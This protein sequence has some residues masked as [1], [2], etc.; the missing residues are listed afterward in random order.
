MAVYLDHNAST[1]L[2]EDVLQAMLP[3]MQTMTGNP[4]S[5]HRFGRLQKDTIERARQ[6]VADLVSAN[7]DQVVFTSG[8]T[9]AN[10]LLVKGMAASADINRMAIS[11]VEH[12]AM[13]EPAAQIA[14]KCAVDYIAVDRD[15]RVTPN[16]LEQAILPDTRLVSVMSANNETGVIQDIASLAEIAGRKN[17]WFHTDAS[18]AAGKIDVSFKDWGVH[19]MTLSSHKIY[20]PPG[21]GALVIDKGLPLHAL[22]HGGVQEQR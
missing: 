2:H 6:Q 14:D 10:N 3:V 9:E 16:T 21:A 18:Q 8:G 17:I 20:G 4:S 13:L 22:L 1:P 5:L 12:M 15:G 11:S 7:P 19:A